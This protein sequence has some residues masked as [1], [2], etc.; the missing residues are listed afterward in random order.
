MR[1]EKYK[2]IKEIWFKDKRI[3]RNKE[4]FYINYLNEFGFGV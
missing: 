3:I 2:E 1:E 4:D